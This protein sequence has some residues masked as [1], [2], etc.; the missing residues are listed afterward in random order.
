[1]SARRKPATGD[2]APGSEQTYRPASDIA[3]ERLARPVD[4]AKNLKV[5]ERH[6]AILERFLR[7]HL[8]EAVYDPQGRPLPGQLHDYYRVPGAPTKALTKLGAEKLA[9]LFRYARGE[10]KTVST[11]ET[12]EY[13]SA[14]VRVVLVDVYRRVVGS[15]EGA[16]STAEAGFRSAKALRR[17]GAVIADDGTVE[18]PADYRA[19]LHDVIARAGK[20]AF[21][22]AVLYATATDELFTVADQAADA[23]DALPAGAAEAAA[24][25]GRLP[26]NRF[27]KYAGQLV[28]D[29]PAEDLATIAQWCRHEAARP[30]VWAPVADAID[31]E[32][33][34]RHAAQD[35]GGEDLPL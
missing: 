3:A 15:G 31:A 35:G 7:D 29:V 23:G 25:G 17:Y 2:L 1:V 13:V 32:L 20:R 8:E 24:G 9:A 27:G 14:T 10:T 26:K 33:A 16:C 4:L 22:Q 11:V 12:P 6:R 19:A 34:R 30:A 18:R 21:V 5:L 28:T